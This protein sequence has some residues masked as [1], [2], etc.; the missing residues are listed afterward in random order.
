MLHV[1]LRPRIQSISPSN[2][3]LQASGTMLSAPECSPESTF[4]LPER[5]GN[6]VRLTYPL[7][8]AGTTSASP[9]KP[10]YT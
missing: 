4:T 9:A 2:Q 8:R 6:G 1:Y 7:K 3:Y 10:G 5:A